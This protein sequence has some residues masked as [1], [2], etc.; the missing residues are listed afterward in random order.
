[1]APDRGNARG[2]SSRGGY[3]A[4]IL[5]NAVLL[6]ILHSIPRWNLPFITA[7]Y[8]QVLWAFDLSI[9]ATIAANLT[10]LV[11]DAPW[12]L[13]LTRAILSVLAFVVAIVLFSVFPFAFGAPA[14]DLLARVLLVLA[15]VGSAIGAIVE[16]VQFVR[17]VSR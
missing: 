16:F 7:E 1:M 12:Y 9:G 3:V 6:F 11:Y 10:Y 13:H 5:V 8:P 2:G 17:A 14:L 15:M 4:A